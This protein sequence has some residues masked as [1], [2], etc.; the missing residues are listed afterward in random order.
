M[1][2]LAIGL[3]A[4]AVASGVWLAVGSSRDRTE[5][6]DEVMGDAPGASAS[7]QGAVETT[8]TATPTP[9][10]P[11]AP[12]ADHYIDD[13]GRLSLSAASLPAR[14]AVTFGLA[15]DEKA[16]G[17]GQD[18]LATVVVSTGDGRRL[19]LSATPVAGLRSGVRLEVDA[20]WLEP[21]LYMIQIRTAEKT[22]LPLRRYVLEVRAAPAPQ[23]SKEVPEDLR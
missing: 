6:R 19:E 11:I 8:P 15:L 7:G 16:L 13:S 12:P 17:T 5:V 22:A 2:W 23:A 1:R 20:A 14:G 4:I 21:G 10:E 9:E 3:V 18:P